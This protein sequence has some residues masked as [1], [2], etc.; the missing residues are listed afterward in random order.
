[1]RLLVALLLLSLMF[2]LGGCALIAAG[3]VGAALERHQWEQQR[4]QYYYH[5]WGR[6]RPA[7][8]SNRGR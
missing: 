6:Y 1:M 7:Y 3:F 5:Q 4:Q 2:P 8:Y